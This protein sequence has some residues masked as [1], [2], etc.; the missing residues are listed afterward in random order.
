MGPTT[1]WYLPNYIEVIHQEIENKNIFIINSQILIMNTVGSIKNNKN[2][3]ICTMYKMKMV[4]DA[5]SLHISTPWWCI[6]DCLTFCLVARGSHKE[7][8]ETFF[9]ISIT[10]CDKQKLGRDR[11]WILLH[12]NK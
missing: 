10:C 3:E 8:K 2:W 7:T 1:A 12:N 6:H 9:F 4:R 11:E 5:K